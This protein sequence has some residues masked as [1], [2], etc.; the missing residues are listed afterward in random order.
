[1][2]KKICSLILL[3]TML[4]TLFSVANIV[5][6]ASEDANLIDNPGFEEDKT[7]KA[8]YATA[9]RT[10]EEMH[11]GEYSAYISGRTGVFGSFRIPVGTVATDGSAAYSVS[12]WMKLEAGSEP[13]NF[14]MVTDP[15]FSNRFGPSTYVTAD[16][17]TKL[18]GVFIPEGSSYYDS[19]NNAHLRVVQVDGTKPFVSFYVDD[20][21]F[22]KSIIN[23]SKSEICGAD[24]VGIPND[25]ELNKESYSAICRDQNGI[26]RDV[27]TSWSLIDKNTQTA[28]VGVTI[29]DTGMLTVTN[30]AVASTLK[31]TAVSTS[32]D[33]SVTIEKEVEIGHSITKDAS[34]EL[35]LSDLTKESPN[36]ITADMELP[37]YDSFGN[38]IEWLCD[39]ADVISLNGKVE[40]GEADIPVTL[41]AK[42]AD[43]FATA[44][45]SFEL[46]VPGIKADLSDVD[47]G[48]T[49]FCSAG[50]NVESPAD[51]NAQQMRY[52]APG[53]IAANTFV[54]AGESPAEVYMVTA[55]YN[56]DT[57]VRASAK[58]ELIPA[59]TAKNLYSTTECISADEKIKVFF[60]EGQSSM[61]PLRSCAELRNAYYVSDRGSDDNSGGINSPFRTIQ[62]AADIMRPG[63]AC[64]VREGTYR[65]TVTPASSGTS[66]EP[67]VFTAYPGERVTISGADEL[68]LS[69]AEDGNGVYTASCNENISQLFVNGDMMNVARWPNAEV[70][71][72]FDDDFHAYAKEA[73]REYITVDGLPSGDLNGAKLYIW[74]GQAW[75]GLKKEIN[76]VSDEDKLSFTVPFIERN[77]GKD[78]GDP[79][80]PIAKNKFFIYGKRSLLDIPTEWVQEN[81]SLYLYVEG[82]GTPSNEKVEVKKR[83]LAFNLDN[84]SGIIVNGFDVFAAAIKMRDASRCVINNCNILYPGDKDYPDGERQDPGANTDYS[85]NY[86]KSVYIRGSDNAVRGCRISQSPEDGIVLKGERNIVYNCVIDNVNTL[87]DA[88]AAVQTEGD[89]NRIVHNSFYRAGRSLIL[90]HRSKGLTVSHN[91]LYE[92]GLLSKDL[93]ATYTYGRDLEGGAQGSV[94]SYNWVHDMGNETGIYLDSY[95]KNYYVHHNVVYNTYTGI[96]VNGFSLNSIVCNNTMVG[97]TKGFYSTTW[98]GYTLTQKGTHIINNII[99]GKCSYAQGENAPVLSHNREG[100]VDERFLPYSDSPAVDGGRTVDDIVLNPIEED[101][102][103]NGTKIA[104]TTAGPMNAKGITDGFVGTAPDIGAYELGGAYWTAGAAWTVPIKAVK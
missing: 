50:D 16:E 51:D 19:S 79:W 76:R 82:G 55:V 72:L 66:D 38:S 74:S 59:N 57:L 83:D 2:L 24:K 56:N 9:E 45:K 11:S 81:D 89:S 67:I 34:K 97:V 73:D 4:A 53:R 25:G 98:S 85:G 33:E 42:I 40:R 62:H 70:N 3:I 102:I 13:Q 27:A 93:G 47:I 101:V 17:W 5:N 69:W 100:A 87:G 15:E 78:P 96:V 86:A 94:I 88:H 91:D 39:R 29:D 8:E 46:I 75:N 52:T 7:I 54:Q 28:P 1:M 10:D 30:D 65:E 63:D 48:K 18:E 35:L 44:Q 6:A 21:S 95:S 12:L 22:Q 64:V 37:R 14:R 61:R 92:G 90:H 36:G 31:I 32:L 20:L 103:K 80:M 71:N 23:N 43:G 104:T 26:V 41:T 84:K 49:Y 77:N 99:A 68:S 58:T 60:F